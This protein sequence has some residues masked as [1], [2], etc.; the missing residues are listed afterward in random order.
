VTAALLTAF[1]LVNVATAN[2]G[3]FA[4]LA[5]ALHLFLLDDR[6]VAR[7]RDWWWRRFGRTPPV[8]PPVPAIA[9]ER[10]LFEWGAGALVLLIFS[11]VS[12]VDGA[13]AFAPPGPWLATTAPLRAAWAPFRLINTYHLFAHITRER[14]EP[15]FQTSDGHT[16]TAHDLRYKAG[17]PGRAPGFVAPHQPR[18][19]FQLWFYGL[20]YR[21][22]TPPWVATLLERMC[23]DPAA[24]SAL[25]REP[26]PAAPRAVRIAFYQY[27]FG[28]GDPFWIRQ[29]VDVT[30]TM[31]CQE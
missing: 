1:Q 28:T 30:E 26:L 11:A 5:L 3:F 13:A 10:E 6:D 23:R 31:P 18:V 4:W 25:F 9:R 14:I 27:H 19:D 12:I 24:V 21:H 22:G 17:D 8:D 16:W 2:Y 15:E 20:S 29:P 7:A